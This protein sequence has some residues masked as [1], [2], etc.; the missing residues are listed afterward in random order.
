MAAYIRL[1]GTAAKVV[2]AMALGALL[3]AAVENAQG[4]AA[5]V[6]LRPVAATHELQAQV[7][8]GP[9]ALKLNGLSPGAKGEL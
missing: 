3:T 2:V 5:K 6:T 1:G 4:G 9:P 7:P 8:K